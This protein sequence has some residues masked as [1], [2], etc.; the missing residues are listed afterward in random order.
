MA[1]SNEQIIALIKEPKA[2]Q[3]LL[4]AVKHEQRVCFHA[5]ESTERE[6]C[7]PYIDDFDRW[8]ASMLPADKFEMFRRVMGF[9]LYTNELVKGIS[10]E[11]AKVYDSQNSSFSYE[12]S[13]ENIEAD[14]RAFLR[15]TDFW[16]KWKDDSAEAMMTAIN[17]IMVIDLP[18]EGEDPKPY[19]YFLSISSVID[20]SLDRDGNILYLI[21]MQDDDHYLIIDEASYQVYKK[22]SQGDHRRELIAPHGLGYCPATFFWKE[23]VKKRTPI[24]KRSPLTPALTNLNWLLYWENARR[25]LE[26]YAAFPIYSAFKEKC[27]YTT[28]IDNKAYSCVNGVIDMG[29]RGPTACPAC[30]KNKLIG[31]GTMFRVP[32]PTN[33][34][35]PSNINSL[36]IYPA[37]RQSLDY[38]TIRSAELWDE[39]FYDCVGY[40]GDDMQ[41]QAVNEKQVRAGFES[42]QNILIGLK[43]NLESSLKFVI[44]TKARL[45]YGDA[46][47]SSSVNLG[48]DFY[49]KSSGE[50][51]KEYKDAK[52]AGVPQYFISNKRDQVDSIST[53]GNEYDAERLNVL[54]HLE[55]WLD[56]SL[57]EAKEMGFDQS[58]REQ[59][60]LK[61]DF[62]RLVSRFEMEY[63]SIVEF[64]S[65]VDFK[66]KIDRIYKTLINY[67]KQE[68]PKTD[69]SQ[70]GKGQQGIPNPAAA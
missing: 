13:N 18:K 2:R 34:E 37:E 51:V 14:F 56:I 3:A 42:K 68:F 38:A 70:S 67:V 65:L 52:D 26:S 31:P 32:M 22:G 1:L 21:A 41:S 36:T 28:T 40:G 19:Y 17:S 8:V 11:Y 5:E 43:E 66:I 6:S 62:S 50:A 27:G 58:Y 63:G 59:F 44:D 49:L 69:N 15:T 53:K 55:P 33:K 12:F 64:G 48:T 9:P 29:E 16:S 61:S 4:K 39:I 23:S 35:Q 30:A 10:E 45:M 46:F 24:V 47:K 60:L 57:K 20:I 25:C 54:K 7:S